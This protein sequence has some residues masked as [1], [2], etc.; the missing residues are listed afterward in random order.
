MARSGQRVSKVTCTARNAIKK[1]EEHTIGPDGCPGGINLR[2]GILAEDVFFEQR[3]VESFAVIV[4]P[5]VGED[6]R[7]DRISSSRRLEKGIRFP[8]QLEGGQHVQC[9]VTRRVHA[10]SESPWWWPMNTPTR[11]DKTAMM[12][13]KMMFS[14]RPWP[15]LAPSLPCDQ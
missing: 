6:R 10:S 14:H 11:H 5:D 8:S 4:E 13:T 3:P 12:T 7:C 2:A 1:R 15:D 9:W